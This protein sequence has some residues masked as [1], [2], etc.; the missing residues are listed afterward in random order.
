[1]DERT[2]ATWSS[3][4]FVS[5][6]HRM[7]GST[8]IKSLKKFF[9]AIARRPLTFHEIIFIFS[10]NS[11][12]YNMRDYESGSIIQGFFL[13]KILIR[14]FQGGIGADG[15]IFFILV[16]LEGFYIQQVIMTCVCEVLSGT[17][18]LLRKY[19]LNAGLRAHARFLL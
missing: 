3:W 5:W 14:R 12:I 16:H 9:L 18:K 6:M 7:S 15:R 13:A 4:A 17:S 11:E 8:P 19:R 1:M 10:S 2:S